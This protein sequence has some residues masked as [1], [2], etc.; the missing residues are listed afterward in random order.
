MDML[1]LF[2]KGV[3][4]PLRGPELYHRGSP[5]G[6]Q[7][8]RTL[9]WQGHLVH[10]RVRIGTRLENESREGPNAL[11]D[12]TSQS[13]SAASGTLRQSRRLR[14]EKVRGLDGGL[15]PNGKVGDYFSVAR[16]PPAIV[17]K[18]PTRRLPWPH[19]DESCA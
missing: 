6:R 5:Y 11:Y 9:R 18:L 3:Y 4:N 12:P 19:E 17:S 2:H 7:V 10:L 16:Y 14:T 15:S 8:G 1:V 13:P